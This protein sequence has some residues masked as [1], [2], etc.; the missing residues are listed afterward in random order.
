[1]PL[2]AYGFV[3]SLGLLSGS[4]AEAGALVL[5]KF[6]GGRGVVLLLLNPTLVGLVRRTTSLLE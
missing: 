4:L 2:G 3:A 5:Q 6:L 1:M